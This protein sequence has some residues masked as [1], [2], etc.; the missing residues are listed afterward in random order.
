MVVKKKK[1]MKQPSDQLKSTWKQHSD[2]EVE[3]IH[4]FPEYQAPFDVF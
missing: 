1:D 2:L 3:I 4:P